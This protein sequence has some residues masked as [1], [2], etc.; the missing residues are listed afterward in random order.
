MAHANIMERQNFV[1][2]ALESGMPHKEIKNKATVLFGCTRQ[3]I[4]SDIVIFLGNHNCIVYIPP[5]VRAVVLQRDGRYCWYCRTQDSKKYILEHVIPSALG[6]PSEPYNLVVAC[7]KCN[8]TK[9]RKVWAPINL[10]EITKD[11]PEHRELVLQKSV[12]I[13]L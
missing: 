9:A 11:H 1:R 10:L 13:F 4:H 2:A 5:K 3:M 8:A 12:K 6:G 7:A